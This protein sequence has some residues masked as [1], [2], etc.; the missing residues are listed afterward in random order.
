MEKGRGLLRALG[1]SGQA[2]PL[3]ASRVVP[4]RRRAG[5]KGLPAGDF[6]G[7]EA[8]AGAHA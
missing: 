1:N 5:R 6:G 7:V 3:L 8:D 4:T 2:L